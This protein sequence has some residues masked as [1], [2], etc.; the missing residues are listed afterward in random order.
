MGKYIGQPIQRVDAKEKVTG[1]ALYPGD[2]NLPGQVWMKILFSQRIHAVIKNIDTAEAESIPGVLAVFTAKDVPNNEYGLITPDQPVLCGP[3]SNK[4][5]ADR[6]RCLADQVAL[7]IAET[8]EI[9]S[10]ARELIRVEYEDLKAVF[11]PLDAME[12]CE[13]LVHPE[14]DSN[15][16]CHYRIRNGNITKGFDESDVIVESDYQTPEQ[17]HAYLQPEAGISY[18]DEVGRITVKVAGQWVHE[19]QEQIAHALNL[20]LEQVR[21]I[22]PAIGGAFGGREDMSV[23][24]VLA[25]ASLRLHQR[26]IDRPIKIIWTREESIIGHHKRHP[27][28]IH[29]KWG[30]KKDG[31]LTA[32]EVKLVADGG[33]YIYT[34]AKVLGNATLLSTGPY[35]IPNVSV[36]SYAVYTNNLPT[37]AFR[38]FGGPQAL[39]EA[40]S[41]MNKLAEKLGIDPVEF[42]MKNVLREGDLLS[43]QTP[44]PKGVAIREVL[45]RCAREAG[46]QE[47]GGRWT[48]PVKHNDSDPKKK[49]ETAWGIACGYK[50]IGFSFGAPEKCWASVEIQGTVEIERVVLH[51]AGAEVGQGSHTVFLQAAAEVLNIP[52]DKIELVAADTAYT[53]NSGS[54]SA[55][56]MT[57]MGGNA[58]KGAAEAAL[59]KWEMEE[60]PAIASYEYRPPETT[61]FDQETGKS[62][63]NFAYGYVAIAVKAEVDTNSGQVVLKKV[64][65]VDDVGQ[66]INPL[67]VKGQIEGA[68]V[69][70]A[71]YALQENFIQG[72]TGVKTKT[73]STYLIPT[74]LDIPE[75]IQSVILEVPDKNGPWGAKGMGE[76]PYLC[77]VPA[78]TSAVHEATG[79][80]FNDFPLIPERI[81]RG[82]GKI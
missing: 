49:K 19:D 32:A 12:S 50:N 81:L 70:A 54:V 48:P 1:E 68:I 71:G 27:F 40:E 22:Y 80:W 35:R 47:T 62:E 20:P 75:E 18:L 9:A 14:R 46:W 15:I 69:Q 11:H 17:E 63:P 38:G 33:G 25:L 67:Q 41:Q 7:V 28:Y 52:L 76:M 44:L 5:Y 56:R 72:S 13:V 73:L 53:Q 64:I 78:V 77:F 23:Q 29:A 10:Q 2:I 31:T 79:I 39:F 59:K 57:F 55:S 3:G 43:V 58:V 60:R 6:V 34:S 16:F 26:G 4:P 24:I 8:E 36:D 45:D 42:R 66:A 82:L 61:P 21:V 51:H 65:C 74:I 30:A 37:G